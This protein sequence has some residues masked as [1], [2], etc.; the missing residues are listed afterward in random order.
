MDKGIS[1]HGLLLQPLGGIIEN[2]FRLFFAVRTLL[3][4]YNAFL[5]KNMVAQCDNRALQLWV[6]YWTCFLDLQFRKLLLELAVLVAVSLCSATL[7]FLLILF[8]DLPTS[9]VVAPVVNVYARIAKGAVACVMVVLAKRRVVIDE[10]R[11]L[12][13]RGHHDRLIHDCYLFRKRALL[14]VIKAVHGPEPLDRLYDRV[15]NWSA[16]CRLFVNSCLI[17]LRKSV[18]RFVCFSDSRSISSK[19]LFWFFFFHFD[20][21]D[22]I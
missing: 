12:Y 8:L 17:S 7:Q 2:A 1:F 3:L 21:L 15:G 9:F 13:I 18:A 5:A 22:W 4:F 19:S 10:P 20:F 16:L 11:E 14:H 6:A